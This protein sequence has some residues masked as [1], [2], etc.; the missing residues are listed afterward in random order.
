MN[1]LLRKTIYFKTE[2]SHHTTQRA[3]ENF[4]NWNS[5]GYRTKEPIEFFRSYFCY[6]DMPH[7]L[8]RA[9]FF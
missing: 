2:K 7:E 9:Y 5:Q 4:I 8:R 3:F 1:V 6:K